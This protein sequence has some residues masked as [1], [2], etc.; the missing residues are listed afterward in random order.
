LRRHIA[1]VLFLTALLRAWNANYSI[2][3][4]QY[5][6]TSTLSNSLTFSRGLTE[7][8]SLNGSANFTALREYAL[9]SFTDGR[10]GRGW[11]SWRPV[12][13][14]E[15]SAEFAR[16]LDLKDMRGRWSRIGCTTAAPGR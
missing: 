15:L 4:D 13:G 5:K 10:S 3:L 12:P 14:L 11:L 2:G 8:L 1:A 9:N 16:S 7:T 6:N